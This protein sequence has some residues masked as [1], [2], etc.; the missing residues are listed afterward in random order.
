M[1]DFADA[2]R[3]KGLRIGATGF[4]AWQPGALILFAIC[5]WLDKDRRG[6]D[7][8]SDNGQ[9]K[10]KVQDEGN[11]HTA[12][13]HLG[14]MTTSI[15]LRPELLVTYSL[16]GLKGR[17]SGGVVVQDEAPSHLAWSPAD[18]TVVLHTPLFPLS[19]N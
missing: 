16:E 4:S 18:G 6:Q 17:W 7:V 13:Y 15:S 1:I 12:M 8:V 9:E 2:D 14:E 11:G 3:V 5:L 10:A 19:R